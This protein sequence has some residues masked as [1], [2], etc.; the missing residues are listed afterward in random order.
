MVKKV[1]GSI[2]ISFMAIILL[3]LL[4]LLILQRKVEAAPSFR[5]VSWGDTKSGT[6]ILS[7]LSDQAVLLN[8]ALTIYTGD[9]E[10]S[11]PTPSGME[12]WKAAIN[13]QLTGDTSSNAI[14]DITFPIRGNH[15]DNDLA[16]WQSF[17]NLSQTAGRVG[18]ANYTF[19]PGMDD[20]TY[21]FDYSNAHFVGMDVA[22]DAEDW[23][24]PNVVAWLD[25]DL[26]SAETR[27]LSHAFI[28]FHG[29]I[30]CVDGHCDCTVRV[31]SINSNLKNLYSIMNRHPIITA[32]F[33]GHEHTYAYTYID[34]T[35]VPSDGSFEGVTHPFHQFVT[36]AAG[37]ETRSCNSNRCDFNMEQ[38]GFITV[39]VSGLT[40][41]VN[42]YKQGSSTP[43]ET[44]T[45]TKQ[46]GPQP[47]STN[48]ATP[49]PIF[50]PSATPSLKGDL[51]RDG[52]ID[53]EDILLC[54]YI[55]LGIEK[56]P[57]IV[58][59][60]DMNGDGAVNALDLQEIV[61]RRQ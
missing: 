35:R 47:T 26:T 23:A 41:T 27:G 12:N 49:S 25:A 1:I 53:H 24:T 39:D 33:H 56:D 19:M 50:T 40:F 18:A 9:L 5:F 22:G 36:G 61:K 4:S 44:R 54:A 52:K 51:T 2:A 59:D 14:F 32:T 31:C 28:Y 55:I 60:A 34:E 30:Y 29:P 13:G 58:S 20:T 43:V 11:G 15:D 45:F 57:M 10:D 7:A 8:P 3:T 16:Y 42:W 46:E 38:Y 17:F 48:P 6:Q 37:A 21:S